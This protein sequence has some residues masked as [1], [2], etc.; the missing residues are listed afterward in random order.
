MF[1]S[2]FECPFQGS[3][4]SIIAKNRQ[5]SEIRNKEKYLTINLRLE[6]LAELIRHPKKEKVIK[7][8]YT[9][10]YLTKKEIK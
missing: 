7:T 9:R 2:P 4:V 5:L 6:N 1:H 3:A 8:S 10:N